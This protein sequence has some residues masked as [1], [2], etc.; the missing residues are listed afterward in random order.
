[1]EDKLIAERLEFEKL[2]QKMLPRQIASCIKAGR[3]PAFEQAE[4]DV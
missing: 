3:Q 1:M 2:L 4:V